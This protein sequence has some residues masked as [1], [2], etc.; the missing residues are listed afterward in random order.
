MTD[1]RGV[2]F[3]IQ[4]YSIHDG[5]GIRTTLFLK[6]CPLRCLW[7]Q[8]PESQSARPELFFDADKCKGCG[9]CVTACP[10]QAITL[11]RGRSWTIR[12]RC[13]GAG[14][15]AEACPNEARNLMGTYMTAEEVFKDVAADAIFYQRSGGGVTLSG[16]DPV[17]QPGFATTLLRMCKEAGIHT[18][19]DTCGHARWETLRP[20]LEY[21]D[22]VLFDLKHIDP[23]EHQKLTGV[24]NDWILENAKRIHHEM[25][26]PLLAR[27]PIVPGYNDS[28]EN[29][30]ATARFIA[31]ELD[32]SIKVHLL[33]YHRLGETK[34]ERLEK[35]SAIF[36]T[37]PPS[38]ARMAEL[39][40]VFAS[41]GLTAVIGG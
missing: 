1:D 21:V 38:D 11:D 34:Y 4:H 19:L 33:P 9:T 7:C 24:S 18:T 3:N 25:H 20:M 39:Q 23:A 28:A 14:K 31:V 27:V 26:I 37:E 5:P 40:H 17:S 2:I 22:L 15:C 6:G 8:N 36:S 13:N 41:F 12:E 16:G 32:R 35:P 29:V 10:E 30:Q